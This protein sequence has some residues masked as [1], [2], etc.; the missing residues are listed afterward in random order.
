MHEDLEG[1]LPQTVLREV[2]YEIQKDT[3]D[4]MFKSFKSENLIRELCFAM[5]SSIYM[6]GDF[7]II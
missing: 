3:L 5:K 1:Y 4:P 2:L 6:P 7:I